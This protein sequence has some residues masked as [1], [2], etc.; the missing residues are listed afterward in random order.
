MRWT[1]CWMQQID[2]NETRRSGEQ[3]CSARRSR[4]GP[5]ARPPVMCA[6]IVAVIAM[7]EVPTQGPGA[8]FLLS[9][10][11]SDD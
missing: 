10:L 9:P 6:A 7:F 5:R 4:H 1:T 2:D 8:L 3:V 11:H